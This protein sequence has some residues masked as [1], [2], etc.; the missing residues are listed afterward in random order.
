MIYISFEELYLLVVLGP[1][2]RG[3]GQSACRRLAPRQQGTGVMKR[4][5][6]GRNYTDMPEKPSC[7]RDFQDERVSDEQRGCK[8]QEYRM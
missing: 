5:M 2:W 4:Y 7:L 1:Y 8:D 3:V 6:Q